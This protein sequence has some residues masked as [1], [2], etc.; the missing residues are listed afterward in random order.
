MYTRVTHHSPCAEQF[1]F[2]KRLNYVENILVKLTAKEEM[3]KC[4]V[5]MS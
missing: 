4:F 3:G 2:L 5:K 1:F